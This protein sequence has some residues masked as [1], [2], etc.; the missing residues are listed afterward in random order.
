[1]RPTSGAGIFHVRQTIPVAK[2]GKLTLLYPEWLPGK[3]APRGAIA[4]VAGFKASAGGKPLTWT[5]QPTDVYAFDI[6]V[7]AGAKSIDI[8]FDF[9]SPTRTS[10]GRVVVTPAMMNLQWEQV[11]L[12]PAGYFTRQI[13][14][15]LDV[16][17]PEGWLGSAAL[18]GLRISGN[19]YSYGTT[20]YGKSRRQSDVRGQIF[21]PMGAR[22]RRDA[23]RRSPTRPNISKPVPIISRAMRR[24]CRKRSPCSGSATTTAMI[25][26]SR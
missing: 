23:Q 11:S 7:P 16:T 6:D 5:R 1:M 12:Y 15:Q 26:C 2:A 10:E 14:V 4:E 13:P 18:D 3:H 24:W 17:L 9:L 25:S 8:V 21:P 19:R 20:S 22:Q